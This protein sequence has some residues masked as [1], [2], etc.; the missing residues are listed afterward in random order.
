[1]AHM[2]GKRIAY[3]MSAGKAEGKKPL[4]IVQAL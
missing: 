4:G 2:G 3:K 1:V